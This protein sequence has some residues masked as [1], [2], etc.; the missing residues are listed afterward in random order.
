MTATGATT[1]SWDN[2]VQN[3]V[4]FTVNTTTTYVVTGIKT[5][6]LG[7][8]FSIAF[9]YNRTSSLQYNTSQTFTP[10]VSIPTET[11]DLAV[12]F[13]KQS[14]KVAIRIDGTEYPGDFSS[15]LP[16]YNHFAMT[17]DNDAKTI[18]LYLNGSLSKTINLSSPVSIK[19]STSLFV[20][21]DG[22]AIPEYMFGQIDDL[23]F[24]NKTYTFEEVVKT[25]WQWYRNIHSYKDDT[26]SLATVNIKT[27]KNPIKVYPNP[28]A[29]IVK[30]S[31]KADVQVFDTLGRLL[32]TYKNTESVNLSAQ[33]QGVY[34]LK[35]NNVDGTQSIKVIKK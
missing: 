34:I 25:Y 27:N 1:Y 3:G 19:P 29:D 6:D 22:K 28:T 16:Q 30:L 14:Q 4:P 11:G 35:L 20:G 13:V 32:G 15:Y 12:G 7:D 21:T 24:V 17:V 26:S 9:A 5:N 2:N 8:K 23:I 31:E 33:K 10:I 18:K